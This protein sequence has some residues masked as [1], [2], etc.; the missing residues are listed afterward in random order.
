PD[1]GHDASPSRRGGGQARNSVSAR[2]PILE[3]PLDQQQIYPCWCGPSYFMGSDRINRIVTSQGSSEDNQTNRGLVFTWQVQLSPSPH[4]VLDGVAA[5]TSG[6]DSGF[7][8]S[9]SSN[10]TTAGSAI[11]WAVGR[12]TGAGP[13]PT[14]IVL[15][16][17]AGA[18]NSNKALT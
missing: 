18:T 9:V 14:A 2:S 1:G 7:F 17:F 11:I 8:T 12:P 15:Y 3:P 13:N 10:G 5:I 16:A 4:L 6:Q